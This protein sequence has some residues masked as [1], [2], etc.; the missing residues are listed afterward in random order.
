MNVN[1]NGTDYEIEQAGSNFWYASCDNNHESEG[2]FTYEDALQS[3]IDREQEKLADNTPD[4]YQH[5]VNEH[6]NKRDFL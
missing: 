2:Y 5:E 1:I 4:T 3:A 6:F